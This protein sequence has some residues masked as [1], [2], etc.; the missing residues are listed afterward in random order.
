MMTP[1]NLEALE[2]EFAFEENQKLTINDLRR[3]LLDEGTHIHTLGIRHCTV[4]H[5]YITVFISISFYFSAV[6]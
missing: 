5:C 6:S 4:Y 2:R 3:E 1:A